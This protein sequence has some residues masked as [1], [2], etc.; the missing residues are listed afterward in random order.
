MKKIIAFLAC[1]LPTLLF[2]GTIDHKYM[3]GA[4]PLVDG[5]VVFTEYIDVPQLSTAVIFAK[6]KEWAI[7][8]FQPSFDKSH[9]RLLY[10]NASTHEIATAGDEYLVFSSSILSLDRARIS[11]YLEIKCDTAKVRLR[12][13]RI[14][15]TYATGEGDQHYRAEKWIT[16]TEAM[17]KK[18][19]KLYPGP[20]KF[21]CKTI[22][23]KDQLF[24]ELRGIYEN[25]VLR[26]LA[27]RASTTAIAP[28][29]KVQPF[30]TPPVPQKE[31]L[32]PLAAN[33]TAAIVSNAVITPNKTVIK[34]LKQL[35]A[36]QVALFTG[37][38]SSF[39]AKTEWV[40]V[41]VVQQEPVALLLIEATDKNSK[42]IEQLT[43]YTLLLTATQQTSE[44]PMAF[45]V[46]CSSLMQQ[47][48]CPATVTLPK[49]TAKAAHK[50]SY[51]LFVGKINAVEKKK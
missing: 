30:S 49:D 21:R 12:V 38:Y 23:L 45:Q 3:A 14:S 31:T 47:P 39:P 4:V 2:G 29:E 43:D 9:S 35:I 42:A 44:K 28:K 51:I 32:T 25:A 27:S 5:S 20:G 37:P 22:D 24:D 46:S 50:A 11:Y 26:K 1:F 36:P 7:Q 8:R 13:G 33:S 10:A 16:D 15:Y 48:F 41:G 34:Q 17:N 6:A 40:G 18:R 19:T